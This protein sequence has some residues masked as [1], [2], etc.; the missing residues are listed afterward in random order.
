MSS[1]GQRGMRTVEKSKRGIGGILREL[2]SYSNK[3]KTPMI[4]AF[5]FAIIGAVL[6]IIGPNL[7]SDI[8]DLI[9]DSLSGEIDLKS[10]ASIGILLLVIY[11]FSA[12]FTYIEHY[13]M[14]TVTLELSKDLR[15]DLSKKINRVPM[16]YFH[17]TP[18]GDILSRVTMMSAPCSRLWPTACLR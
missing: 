4:I 7:L 6:T 13:I 8:T 5:L 18:F 1:F 12:L 17:S 9:S 16:K 10:I 2:F 3:L 14:A 11:V 15:S